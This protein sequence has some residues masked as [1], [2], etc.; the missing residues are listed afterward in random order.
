LAFRNIKIEDSENFFDILALE[1]VGGS[2]SLG[3]LSDDSIFPL[4]SVFN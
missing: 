2:G 4:Y 3:A 1:G